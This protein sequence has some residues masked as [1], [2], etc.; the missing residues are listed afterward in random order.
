MME[1]NTEA[2]INLLD[3]KDEEHLYALGALEGLEGEV[4]V[5]DSNTFVLQFECQIFE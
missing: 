3:L 1:N 4:L 5:M 2:N